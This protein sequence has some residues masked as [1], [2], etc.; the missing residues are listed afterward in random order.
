MEINDIGRVRA[1]QADVNEFQSQGID[2]ISFCFVDVDLYRPVLAA[3][4]SV[5]GRMARGGIVAVHDCDPR[6]ENPYEGA[7]SAY[8]GFVRAKELA[9]HIRERIGVLRF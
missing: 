7:W 8:T 9:E 2:S 1:I 3:L 6:A 5:C 4:N